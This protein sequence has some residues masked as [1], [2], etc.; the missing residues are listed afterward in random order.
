LLDVVT[1]SW[2]DGRDALQRARADLGAHPSSNQDGCAHKQR[3]DAADC[4][5]ATCSDS[6]LAEDQR[7]V[8]DQ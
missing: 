3:Q 1:A 5:G 2:H 7:S 8:F 6:R 4:S